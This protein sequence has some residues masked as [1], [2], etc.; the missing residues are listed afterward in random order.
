MFLTFTHFLHFISVFCFVFVLFSVCFQ[1]LCVSLFWSSS[2]A[3][4]SVH[5]CTADIIT[6]YFLKLEHSEEEASRKVH[7]SSLLRSLFI[8]F[9]SICLGSMFCYPIRILRTMVISVFVTLTHTH[10]HAC[11]TVL[12]LC[13]AFPFSHWEQ[14]LFVW[15]FI[16]NLCACSSTFL[17][18]TFYQFVCLFVCMC[19]HL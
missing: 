19:V 15:V 13:S 8:S 11:L 12:A 2:V 17:F 9:G 5:L 16:L 18:L 1:I 10:M 7:F 6:N 14:L 4:N 3:I